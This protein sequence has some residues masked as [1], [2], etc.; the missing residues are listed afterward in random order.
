MVIGREREVTLLEDAL[1]E[2]NRGEGR[3]VLVA[4]DAGMGKTRLCAELQARARQVGM[5]V[6]IGGCS[7]ADLALPYLPFLEALGNHLAQADLPELRTR[8]GP[9]AAELTA[10]FPQLDATPAP[11]PGDS[12]QGKLRLF[13]AVLQLVSVI[14]RGQGLLLC[15]E[16]LH[17]AD[18]STRELLDYLARRIRGERILLLGTY[19]RD[20]M[21][22]RHPLLP[23]VQGWRRSG[24]AS[25]VELDPLDP[26]QVGE[27]VRAMLSAQVVGEELRVFLHGRSE[28]NPFVLE[29]LVK[30]AL[31]AG[32]IFRTE[33][34]WDRR[35]L[36]DFRLPETVRDTILLRLDRLAPEQAAVLRSASVLGQSFG[37]ELLRALTERPENEVRDALVACVQQQLLEADPA[38]AGNF[39]FRHAL[40]REAVYEDLIQPERQQLHAAAAARLQEAG[41]APAVQV[42]HHLLAA[43]RTAE[44][45]P[46]CLEAGR[47]AAA[48]H[49]NRDAAELFLKA[50]PHV[51]APEERAFLL[52]EL[53]EAMT[54]AEDYSQ[55]RRY[56]GQGVE[57]LDKL[58][59]SRE[60]AR[61]RLSLGL[62]L[63]RLAEGEAAL[64]QL[65]AAVAVLEEGPFGE[66]LAMGYARLANYYLLELEPGR[67]EE[68]ARR[69]IEVAEEV[70]AHLARLTGMQYLGAALSAQ[71]RTDEG[72]EYLDRS[73]DEASAR[74]WT[75]V[76]RTAYHNA[77]VFLTWDR[78]PE[79]GARL[80]KLES[81]AGDGG[82]SHAM[83]TARVAVLRGDY[84]A[85]AEHQAAAIRLMAPESASAFQA[86]WSRAMALAYQGRLDEAR[87]ELPPLRPGLAAQ[88]VYGRE[89]GAC[90][91]AIAGEEAGADELVNR[92]VDR[93]LEWPFLA[94]P[95]F[96]VERAIE[97]GRSEG[98]LNFAT[99]SPLW[100]LEARCLIRVARGEL[101]EAV[102]DLQEL[103]ARS[104]ALGAQQAAD[105]ARHLLALAALERGDRERAIAELRAV[106]ESADQ[107]GDSI[108]ARQSRRALEAA[109]ESSDPPPP[110]APAQEEPVTGERLV[111]VLFADIRGFTAMTNSS[112]PATIADRISAYQRWCKQEVE[113][114]RGV[115]DKF[116][117]D[118]VMATFNVNGDQVDHSQRALEAGFGIRDR[119]AMLGLQV[120]VGVATGPAVVGSLASGANLSV[121]GPAT[122][123]AS[124]LQAAAGPGEIVLSQ[125]TERRVR[126]WLAEH[127]AGAAEVSLELKGFD[128]PV[129]A[130][131]LGS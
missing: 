79:A 49:A 47:A 39:R 54:R 122:N 81:V 82:A 40:T 92:L 99:M 35:A 37:F 128:A 74:G 11:D 90:V 3:A 78:L 59:R 124:R 50:L 46:L 25:V 65:Q 24:L 113:R 94:R 58:G 16:D 57:E 42:A 100:A 112:E 2:A 131:R 123:L 98:L 96:L 87:A 70:G 60:A 9:A 23:T 93:W 28:G 66:D 21:H 127:G 107:R 6:L 130:F 52:C 22:R 69:C 125:E 84:K 115:V 77:L 14:A 88:E 13:E 109:G 26:P 64:R 110:A 116:A 34:G 101:A 18:A 73:G 86:R 72:L 8:L 97:L 114:H 48:S 43:G 117:G 62:S 108:Q 71:G 118:A 102:P 75:W 10:L 120:G 17:W 91:L 36:A 95:P 106:I 5:S 67:V 76:A 55:A 126:G 20:E 63:I 7:E 56:L 38:L 68:Y 80:A 27:M 41:S 4:G 83:M 44:A 61:H 15:L 51:T 31:D 12:M 45:V 30:A 104:R 129:A 53:G 33:K 29:E 111:S 121:L 103:Q 19:R 32:D 89:L 119:A 1:L 105:K 85:A